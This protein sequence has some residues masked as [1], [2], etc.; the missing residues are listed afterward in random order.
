M[1]VRFDLPILRYCPSF[2]SYFF[3]VT[4]I[5]TRFAE[6]SHIDISVSR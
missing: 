1:G 4:G 2:R 5:D 3:E 6:R